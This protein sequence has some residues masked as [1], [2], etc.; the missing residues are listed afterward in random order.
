MGQ[1]RLSLP[2]S[3]DHCPQLRQW[4]GTIALIEGYSEAFTDVLELTVHEIF[5]NAVI[6]GHCDDV[7]HPVVLIFEC[8]VSEEERYLEVRV[9][10]YGAGFDSERVIAAIRS[11]RSAT[12]SGGRGLFLANHYVKSFR[13]EKL[14]DGCVVVLRYIPY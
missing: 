7:N 4:I 8:G 12:G 11:A 3:I 14:A 13:I 1:Y 9:R 10:D 2:S 5:V 6:H